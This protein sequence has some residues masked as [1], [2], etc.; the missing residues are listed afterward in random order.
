MERVLIEGFERDE[1]LVIPANLEVDTLRAK[2]ADM[3]PYGGW[4][5]LIHFSNGVKTSDVEM[6]KP[7]SDRPLNKIKMVQQAVPDFARPGG[8][9]LDIGC[10]CGYNS[11]WL[12]NTYGMDVVGIEASESHAAVSRLLAQFSGLNRSTFKI[13]DAETYL[14]PEA[15]DLVLHFGTLY[16]LRNPIRALEAASRNLKIGGVLALETQCHGQK[17]ERIARFVRGFNGDPSN[18]WA[19]GDGA[20]S[21]IL[22]FCGFGEP[23]EVFHWSSP[24]LDG[25]YRIIWVMRKLRP[26]EETYE[27]LAAVAKP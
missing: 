6:A 25:M 8:R 15:F 26:V 5:H 27:E 2:L 23:V 24:A 13:A 19:L 9:A 1:T 4:R 12:A 18:W 10:N 22:N 20:L 11:L 16:H 3:R 17:G 14:E 21:D 7:W